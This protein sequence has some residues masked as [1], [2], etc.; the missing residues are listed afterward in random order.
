MEHKVPERKSRWQSVH[1]VARVHAT[2][3]KSF[4]VLIFVFKLLTPET[5]LPCEAWRA[6]KG[7]LKPGNRA[8]F[9]LGGR[10][11]FSITK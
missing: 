6:E 4:W 9:D 10:V 8:I 1:K 11:I 2:G 7:H 5:C 3:L